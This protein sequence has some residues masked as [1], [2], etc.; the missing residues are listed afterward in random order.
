MT[1][2]S[3]IG[4]SYKFYILNP[5]TPHT[6]GFMCEVFCLYDLSFSHSRIGV[7]ILIWTDR[8]LEFR[9][10]VCI[11]SSIHTRAPHFPQHSLSLFRDSVFNVINR[12]KR[13]WETEVDATPFCLNIVINRQLSFISF[14]MNH[15]Q[16][17]QERGGDLTIQ[18][19]SLMS[20]QTTCH[21]PC[22]PH[23]IFKKDHIWLF[24]FL[25]GRMAAQWEVELKLT[26][27]P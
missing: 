27:H 25:I 8:G 2:V 20:T 16:T 23:T 10:V 22:T 14:R 5:P 26:S 4:F 19:C 13:T 12:S 24:Y 6:R 9:L 18:S 21:V 1:D 7:T 3:T 15:L 11:R 17:R